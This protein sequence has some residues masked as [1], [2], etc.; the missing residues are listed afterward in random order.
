MNLV[1]GRAAKAAIYHRALCKAVC[2]GVRTRMELDSYDLIIVPVTEGLRD[3]AIGVI[4]EQDQAT[5]PWQRQY[6]DD[7]SG[8]VLNEDLVKAARAGEILGAEKM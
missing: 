3:L 5:D 4:W 8:K 7:V 2:R 1:A 6:W